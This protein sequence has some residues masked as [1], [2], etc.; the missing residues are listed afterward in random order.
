MAEDSGARRPAE[1]SFPDLLKNTPSNI[2]RLEDEIEQ[3]KGHQKYLAQTS[4]PSDGGDVRWYFNKV[5][6]G[7]DGKLG[8]RQQHIQV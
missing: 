1:K 2:R 4:S 3:C 7:E 8:L 5:P 6:L